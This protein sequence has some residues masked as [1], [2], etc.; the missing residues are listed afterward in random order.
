MIHTRRP[1]SRHP[2]PARR[3]LRRSGLAAVLALIFLSLI[4]TIVVSF[5]SVTSGHWMQ[6]RSH[7]SI[8]AARMQAEGGL[9]LMLRELA[10]TRVG[11]ANDQPALLQAI[12]TR[13]RSSMHGSG[14]LG[15]AQIVYDPLTRAIIIPPIAT[16]EGAFSV[17]IEG[18]DD[19]AA[20]RVF[21]TGT[22]GEASRTVSIECGLRNRIGG[23]F[24]FGVASRGAIVLT[25]NASIHGR[26]DANEAHILSA[27][28]DPPTA[29]TMTGNC[30]IDGDVSISNPYG[31]VALTG[32][33][34]IGGKSHWDPAIS[35]HIHIGVGDA[36]FPEVDPNEFEPYATSI[37]DDKTKT[38]G[39]CTF[40]NI[41]ILA[42]TDPTFSGN[43][44][45]RGVVY[46]EAPNRVHFSGNTT[47]TGVV[48]TESGNL[49]PD[50]ESSIK[51]SGNLSSRG[52]EELPD[53]AA[54]REIREKAGS[55]L[56]APGFDV[57]LVG[58]FGTVNG[59]IAV[60]Q[61]KL[62]GNAGGIVEGFVVTYGPEELRLTG[63]SRLIIDRS[64]GDDLPPGFR[65]PAKL[66]PAP[67]T[68]VEH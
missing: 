25:G 4:A 55:F 15:E 48:V 32:N 5:G 46:I 11:S 22:S 60:E 12:A 17:R 23:A 47:I 53:T 67:D 6:G 42:N 40:E 21:V 51:F 41:R 1:P 56:L 44:T 14:N 29:V 52:V 31:E 59:A 27:T 35:Q 36:D 64:E 33:V 58:N 50:E 18:V 20:V 2:P 37:V 49:H 61:L 3:A 54:F 34:T 13:L 45:I 24:P 28:Y 65:F 63:N 62:T 26:T 66:A 39:N 16:D 7:A 68:Y 8:V 43:T 38:N 57:E 10:Q 19:V 9:Q 30:D